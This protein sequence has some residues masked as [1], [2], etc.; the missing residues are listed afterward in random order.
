MWK[1]LSFTLKM[2]EEQI[3]IFSASL[4]R[5][6]IRSSIKYTRYDYCLPEEYGAKIKYLR[7]NVK[8]IENVIL[9]CHC[10]NDLGMATANAIVVNGARQIECTINGIGERAGNTALEEVVMIFKQHPYLNLYTDIETKQLNEMSRL[11]SDSRE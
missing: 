8:G 4:R 11:V 6:K 10:H 7:E 2:L 9:S 1:M 5:N 3:M